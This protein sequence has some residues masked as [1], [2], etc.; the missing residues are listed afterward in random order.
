MS[1]PG[2]KPME[3]TP[4]DTPCHTAHGEGT[5]PTCQDDTPRVTTPIEMGALTYSLSRVLV[6]D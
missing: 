5:C 4:V 1:G 6:E 2:A 3:G